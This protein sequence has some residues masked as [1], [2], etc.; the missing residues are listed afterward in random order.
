MARTGKSRSRIRRSGGFR[1]Q[2]CS[3]EYLTNNGSKASAEIDGTTLKEATSNVYDYLEWSYNTNSLTSGTRTLKLS[4]GSEKQIIEIIIQPTLESLTV[5]AGEQ[6]LK[7]MK[8]DDGYMVDVPTGTEQLTVTAA[9]TLKRDPVQV[10][11]QSSPA[12]IP[13]EDFEVTVGG[14]T[15]FPVVIKPV[16]PTNVSFATDPA[17]AAVRR[18][19]DQDGTPVQ[20]D[21]DGVYSLIG[22]KGYQLYV[23]RLL[24]R[25]CYKGRHAECVP[26]QGRFA[27]RGYQP[28]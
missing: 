3:I 11:G 7:V 23:S 17:E 19:L 5:Q 6:N 28:Y 12:T 26:A 8:T 21:D 16:K 25:L 10:N 15:T 13:V 2:N 27:G 4:F 14:T 1:D 24:Q 20:P 22:G 18:L 9:A